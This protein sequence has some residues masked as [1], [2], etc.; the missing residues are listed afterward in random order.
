MNRAPLIALLTDFGS[1]DPY[2]GIL[3]AVISQIAPGTPIL[4]LTHEVPPGDI[5]RAA[6]YLWQSRRFFPIETVFVCV[7]DP[8]VGTTRR[9]I[10]LRSNSQTFIGP[11]N[12][13]F[14]FVMNSDDQV[15]ELTQQEYMLSNLST[16]FH[17]RDVFAPVAAHVALGVEVNAFG[18]RISQPNKLPT[19][20]LEATTD[21]RLSGE[22]LYSDR[23]GNMLTSLGKFVEIP[24][25]E[26]SL[27]PW[28]RVQSGPAIH[29]NYSPDL[30]FLWLPSGEKL[31]WV[32]TFANLECDECGFLVGSS[33]LLEI[34]ANR[35]R[36]DQIL[37]LSPHD[38]I[39]LGTT[40][41]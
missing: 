6:I 22:I 13:I 4:D 18:P 39:I 40:G 38:P 16:T 41:M 28:V 30:N 23:F 20:I 17:G 10:L 37:K 8:G 15:W 3:K 21:G 36:A 26:Y 14:S 11:D 32:H 33:G 2:A 29:H 19:P 12:G 7:V 27:E 25:G 5:L 1:A 35:S 34:A 9:G 24:T 31:R